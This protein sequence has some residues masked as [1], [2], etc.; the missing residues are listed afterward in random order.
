[1]TRR[2]LL[3]ALVLLLPGAATAQSNAPPASA[4]ERVDVPEPTAQAL[5]YHRSGNVLWVFNT[6]WGLL[7]PALL[8]WT[9]FSARMRDWATRIGRKWFFIVAVYWVIFTLVTT[10]VDLPRV[11][12]ESFVRQH[13]YGL[14]N[15]TIVKWVS[16]QVASLGITLV[17]GSLVLWIPYL[18]LARSPRRWWLYTAMVA[19]PFI[20]LIQLITP[21]WIDPLFNTFG[22]MKDKALEVDILRLA[23]RSGIEGGRVY[24]VAKSVDTKQL[25][26]Y[27]NGFGATQRIVLWD[28]IIA[29]M[30][31]PQ[32]LTVMG[33]EMGHYV[34]KH[35]WQLI[36]V[37]VLAV[38]VL[39]Y[40]V[41]RLSG[42]LIARYSPRFGFT[43]LADVAS[44]PLILLLVSTVG[45]VVD[46]LT[47]AFA[48]H[49]EHEADRF[50][51]ELTHDNHAFGSALVILQ[52]ENLGVPRPGWLYTWFRE[53]HPPLG[54]RVD[55]AND[56]R[57]WDTGQPLVYA[58]RFK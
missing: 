55:F 17:I 23:D 41:Y 28:T 13:A 54:E 45:L 42:A 19:I 18:L 56:Y 2:A 37:A 21:I 1:V 38:L 7:V 31:R 51:L 47:L 44:L 16:D 29:A 12:Y 22:P 15:Q 34:L 58:D 6:A 52:Q 50:T 10:V 27:V 25:N 36:A 48:R 11:Y 14:S 53:N 26:A 39:L 57:P 30:D 3:L 20:V 46:P 8:L 9:G 4:P 5:A 40:A 32:L 24:E 33:H 49:I 35:V 43:S